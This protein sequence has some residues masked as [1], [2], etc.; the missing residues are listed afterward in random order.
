MQRDIFIEGKGGLLKRGTLPEDSPGSA[1][2]SDFSYQIMS[3]WWPM[4]KEGAERLQRYLGR[5]WSGFLLAG[6]LGVGIGYEIKRNKAAIEPT[7][8]PKKS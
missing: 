6:I 7:E 3:S 5:T 1:D 8:K 2:A 4:T